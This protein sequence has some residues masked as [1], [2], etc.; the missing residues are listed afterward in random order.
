MTT[1]AATSTAIGPATGGLGG[2]AG[3]Y[4]SSL[5]VQ[6][7]Q[8]TIT[9]LKVTMDLAN[10]GTDPVTVAVISPVGLSV[11]DLPNLFQIQPG[12]HFVG[13]FDLNASTPI[14]EATGPSVSGTFIPE[15]FFSDPPAHIDG[16]DPNG[17]WGLVFVGSAGDISHLN[18]KGW[19]LTI[20]TPDPTTV[21]DA[22]GNYSFTGLA[23]GSYQVETLLA[24]G[25]V[26]TYPVG[27][28]SQTV[29]VVDGQ[30][31][32]G[33]NFGIQPASDLATESFYLSAPATSWGQD[34]TINYT[35]TNQGNGDAP[36]FD[37]AVL[38][39]ADDE[40]SPTDTL[41]QTLHFNGLA[42]HASTSGSVSVPLPATPP[43]GFGATS[44]AVIGF[45]ID[46][47]HALAHNVHGRRRQ[48]GAW[49]RRGGAGRDTQPGGGHGAGRPAEPVDRRRPGEPRP[50]RRRVHG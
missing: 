42:A 1:V 8:P 50:H 30:T 20:T 13:S 49:H 19:S 28:A 11:P 31:A 10:N 9:D 4:M 24:P 21:T 33:V 15:Q 43:A 32:R 17:T 14:T 34:V 3:Y 46:P 18:L 7:L 29:N 47:T 27:G 26:Q 25:D 2:I 23:P 48:P 36:A 16:T 12:E 22:S 37:V 40:I 5:Q 38:L 39:S 35:L 45:L 6:G 41:L 44:Q